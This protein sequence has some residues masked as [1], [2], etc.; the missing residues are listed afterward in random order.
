MHVDCRCIPAIDIQIV[1]LVANVLAVVSGQIIV[2]GLG[3]NDDAAVGDVHAENKV[4]ACI[5][6]IVQQTGCRVTV[7][8]SRLV[9]GFDGCRTIAGLGDQGLVIA[10]GQLVEQVVPLGVVVI[11][12][13]HIDQ[14]EAVVLAVDKLIGQGRRI[15]GVQGIEGIQLCQILAADGLIVSIGSGVA[16]CIGAVDGVAPSADLVADLAIGGRPGAGPVVAGQILEAAVCL[17]QLV[18]DLHA[19]GGVVLI[20]RGIHGAVGRGIGRHKPGVAIGGH[21]VC[22][23]LA[24][25]RED[26]VDRFVCILSCGDVVVTGI[27]DV[28]LGVS[29]VVGLQLFLVEGDRHGLA[30]TGSQLRGLGVTDQFNG[31]F[32]HLVGLVVI[33]VRAL[34]VDFHN[35]LA[36]NRTGV[37]DLDR[38]GA[39]IAIPAGVVIRP[40]KGGVGQAV[41][42]G[43]HHSIVVVVIARIALTED[44]ILVTG[45][46]VAVAN[47][48]ALFVADVV[49]LGEVAILIVVGK[50]AEVLRRRAVH[51]IHFI[52][53][54]SAAGRID[55][56]GEDFC[57]RAQTIITHSGSRNDGVNIGI[58]FDP[59][60]IYRCAGVQQQH[61]IVKVIVQILQDLQLGRIRLQIS[62]GLVLFHIGVVVH[63]AGHITA[64]ARHTAEHKNRNRILHG[65]GQTR[66]C[67]HDGQGALVDGEVLVI[68]VRDRA[69]TQ[70]IILAVAFGIEFPEVLVDTEPGIFK[71]R[72][73][74]DFVAA[75]V[76]DSRMADKAEGGIRAVRH[77]SCIVFQ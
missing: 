11:Q 38:H 35:V 19:G 59:A 71:G 55:L 51:G 56:A 22:H 33:G 57:Q 15:G 31:S 77:L 27:Q 72:F 23:G 21:A 46:V 45:L 10:G 54:H 39:G 4:A 28:G 41:A 42:E 69:D 73:H 49:V 34:C 48:D 74:I 3:Q 61:H 43:V 29:V 14:A 24:L 70:T 63:G 13:T 32:F 30:C 67:L 75:D 50:V 37:G 8:C 5:K 16:V 25:G 76:A 7:C 64:F 62:L 1:G 60:Q 36:C 40:V 17:I 26:V 66:L 6:T 20:G 58:V 18:G 65:I 52:G 9:H 53:I 44:F 2:V 47:I 68:T 12:T